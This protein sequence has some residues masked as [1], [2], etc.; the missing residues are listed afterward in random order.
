VANAPVTAAREGTGAGGG[1]AD[2]AVAGEAQKVRE[3]FF[4]TLS[5]ET[6][7]PLNGVVGLCTIMEEAI[8]S[9]GGLVPVR[10]AHGHAP[11]CPC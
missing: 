2:V 6:R 10:P 4:A 5:H 9:L 7:N 1:R 8:L 3:D 11:K